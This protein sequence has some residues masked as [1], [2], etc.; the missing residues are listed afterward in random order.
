MGVRF[1]G[2][3]LYKNSWVVLFNKK[4]WAE[5]RESLPDAN[6]F[7]WMKAWI[8]YR[9]RS[10]SL[11]MAKPKLI[12]IDSTE[13][14]TVYLTPVAAASSSM[15]GALGQNNASVDGP[16]SKKLRGDWW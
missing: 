6:R 8:G 11:R 13:E 9:L 12:E 5:T 7:H 16:P 1:L 14:A 15:E 10:Y 3:Q 4:K 2:G